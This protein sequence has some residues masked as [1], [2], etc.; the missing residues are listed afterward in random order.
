LDLG[1]GQD[2]HTSGT[3]TVSSSQFIYILLTLFTI[4]DRKD[5][6]YPVFCRVVII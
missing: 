2:L 6:A 5:V 3:D 1:Q 4:L